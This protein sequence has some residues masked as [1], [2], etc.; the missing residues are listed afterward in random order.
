ML[1]SY[2]QA[3]IVVEFN[4]IIPSSVL[5][6]CTARVLPMAQSISFVSAT[7]TTKIRNLR[8]VS[9]TLTYLWGIRFVGWTPVTGRQNLSRLFYRDFVPHPLSFF[10]IYK[11]GN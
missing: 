1:A 7:L 3:V 5:M 6:L 10:F 11:R 9:L 8:L 4:K 2:E